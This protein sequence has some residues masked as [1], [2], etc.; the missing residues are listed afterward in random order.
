[1]QYCTKYTVN[2]CKYSLFRVILNISYWITL[3]SVYSE[4][5]SLKQGCKRIFC[6]VYKLDKYSDIKYHALFCA[7]FSCNSARK[8]PKNLA[9]MSDLTVFNIHVIIS[10]RKGEKGAPKGARSPGRGPGGQAC[11]LS[12]EYSV[13]CDCRAH[14]R[15]V[16]WHHC[17]QKQTVPCNSC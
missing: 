6:K 12:V 17:A 14:S 9:I 1:M 4:L 7:L 16:P 3:F 11:T 13:P 2:P 15:P 10:L 8:K 5:L